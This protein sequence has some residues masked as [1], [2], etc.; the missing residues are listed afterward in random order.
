MTSMTQT[1][2]PMPAATRLRMPVGTCA[3]AAMICADAEVY[4]KGTTVFADRPASVTAR[5][6]VLGTTGAR[7]W[8]PPV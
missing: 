3:R 6:H 4:I 1:S 8:S 5:P 7:S 2:W